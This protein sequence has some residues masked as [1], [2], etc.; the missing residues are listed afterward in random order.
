[1]LGGG[2]KLDEEWVCG[3][4]YRVFSN[5]LFPPLHPHLICQ[6][7]ESTLESRK[8]I[9]SLGKNQIKSYHIQWF[10][11]GMVIPKTLPAFTVLNLKSGWIFES[12]RC[13]SPERP[14]TYDNRLNCV[15]VK[16]RP[17]CMLCTSR[18]GY[19]IRP[20]ATSGLLSLPS[21]VS[22]PLLWLMKFW[23]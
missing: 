19:R 1:M 9:Q 6:L 17:G 16:C 14:N 3:I 10:G 12:R 22:P 7:F 5:L 8:I 2:N 15:L 20:T 13:T 23:G 21:S 4:D 18:W 11:T